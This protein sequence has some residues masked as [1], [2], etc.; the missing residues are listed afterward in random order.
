MFGQKVSETFIIVHSFIKP[1][2]PLV[3]LDIRPDEIF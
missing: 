2:G 1:V 3:D